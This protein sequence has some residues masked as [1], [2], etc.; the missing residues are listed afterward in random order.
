[1]E[2]GSVVAS[3]Q[4]SRVNLQEI[5]HGPFRRMQLQFIERC[6]TRRHCE[7]FGSDRTTALNIERRI[8]NYNYLF[9][10]QLCPQDAAGPVTGGGG[11][12]IPVLMVIRESSHG[13]CFPQPEVSQL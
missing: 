10:F 13:E 1:M 2:R 9:R 7:H 4:C 3:R 12:F 11:N 8:A 5:P 6:P